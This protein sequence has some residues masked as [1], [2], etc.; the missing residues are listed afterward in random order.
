MVLNLKGMAKLNMQ[1]LILRLMISIL[2]C[3]CQA[4]D[5]K[6]D[7]FTSLRKAMVENQIKARG[8]KDKRV[9]DAMLKVERHL[10]VPEEYVNQAYG[11]FPLPISEGQTISQPYI[12]ALMTQVLD[13]NNTSKVLE[14]GTGSGYQAAILGEICDSVYTI[15]IYESL[16]ND[17]G[18]TLKELG[19][20]N[21][22]VKAGDGFMGWEEHRPFDAIVVTCAPTQVPQALIDQLI[23]GGKLVIPLGEANNQ[24]L[25]LFEKKDGKLVKRNLVAV[26][27]VPMIDPKGK[28]Y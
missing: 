14:I 5:F 21:V 26:R 28:K 20:N 27:F 16:A 8:I 25:V 18:K 19:Y 24:Q 2:F 10:F 12:V 11:D 23:E 15:E 3:D 1:K 4:Q 13:L 17:A 9:M 22:I 7:N 6:N